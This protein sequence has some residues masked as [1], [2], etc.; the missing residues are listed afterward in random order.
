[1]NRIDVILA[2]VLTLFAIR[3]FW[4]GFSREFFGFIGLIGGIA[5]AAAMYGAVAA[6]IPEPVPHGARPVVA[7][8]VLFFTVNLAANLLGALVHHLLGLVFL[9]PVNRIAGAAFGA[10]KGAALMLIALLLMRAYVPVPALIGAVEHSR[11][12][13]PLLAMAEEVEHQKPPAGT[14]D[15]RG[16]DTP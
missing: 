10:A 13:R 6:S 3:G 5:I 4:R 14:G 7:F 2:I 1:V 12:A 9:S 15:P 8:A 11:L 16:A